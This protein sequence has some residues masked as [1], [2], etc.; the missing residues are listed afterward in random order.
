MD[1]DSV[2]RDLR[3]KFDD[4]VATVIFHLLEEAYE[5]GWTAGYGEGYDRGEIDAGIKE[6][7]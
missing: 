4:E 7:T 2:I 5:Y 1:K 3:I 6:R